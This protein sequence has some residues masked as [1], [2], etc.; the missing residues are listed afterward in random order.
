MQQ[1]IDE[2]VPDGPTCRSLHERQAFGK[3]Q[4]AVRPDAQARCHGRMQL[5]AVCAHDLVEDWWDEARKV[6]L[7]F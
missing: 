2:F 3:T 5:A 1:A 4:S 6:T 7:E